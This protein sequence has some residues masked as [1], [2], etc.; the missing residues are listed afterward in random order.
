MAGNKLANARFEN[1]KRDTI[2]NVHFITNLRW[3]RKHTFKNIITMFSID[4]EGKKQRIYLN[5][6][7]YKD[8]RK[9]F[10]F[11]ITKLCNRFKKLVVAAIGIIIIISGI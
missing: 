8:L 3:N 6:I 4:N 1:H 2:M 9:Q 10:T 5:G 11:T 7:K